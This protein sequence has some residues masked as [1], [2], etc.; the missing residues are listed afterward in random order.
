MRVVWDEPKRRANLDKHGFDFADLTMDFFADAKIV[1]AKAGRFVAVGRLA[2]GAVA[3]HL[4]PPWNRGRLDHLDAGGE[5]Q[6]KEAPMTRRKLGTKFEPGRGYSKTDWRAVSDNPA[7]TDAQIV[8]AK[9][10][11]EAFPDL[12]ESIRRA[13]GRPRV[14]APKQAVTLR[15]APTTLAKFQASGENWRAKMAQALDKAKV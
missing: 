7:L 11:T 10:F 9:P 14:E 1:P 15:L 8:R 12:A 2:A 4:L 3:R 13:R 5:R 6:G